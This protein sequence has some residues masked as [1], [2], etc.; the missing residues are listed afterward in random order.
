MKIVLWLAVFVPAVF[1]AMVAYVAPRARTALGVLRVA[2]KVSRKFVLWTIVL[3]VGMQLFQ[4][5]LLP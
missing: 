5:L 4:A 3:I 2:T 1:L